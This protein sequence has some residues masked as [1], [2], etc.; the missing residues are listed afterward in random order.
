[1]LYLTVIKIIN[2]AFFEIFG[3]QKT[4]HIA[5]DKRYYHGNAGEKGI[6]AYIF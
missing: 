3:S 2:I 5:D 1:M 4:Y 6:F